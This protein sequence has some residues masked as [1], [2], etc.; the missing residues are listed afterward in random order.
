MKAQGKQGWTDAES[1]L[2]LVM[3][4]L[5]GGDC[6]K[7]VERLESDE[8]FCRLFGKAVRQGLSRK[9]RMG[10]KKRWRKEKNRSVPSNP[11][12]VSVFG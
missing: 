3:L 2:S 9:G 1:V 11:G 5:V 8:G 4:N 6:V 10:L 7:D 12:G